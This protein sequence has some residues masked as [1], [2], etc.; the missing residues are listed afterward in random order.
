MSSSLETLS[1]LESEFQL[2]YSRA[3]TLSQDR[4]WQCHPTPYMWY[5]RKRYILASSCIQSQSE[6]RPLRPNNGCNNTASRLVSYRNF[7]QQS[8]IC[9]EYWKVLPLRNG[10]VRGAISI[11][12][13]LKI[14][15]RNAAGHRSTVGVVTKTTT[16]TSDILGRICYTRRAGQTSDGRDCGIR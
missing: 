1:G 14:R 4:N 10:S 15:G 9:Q 5:I 16:E 2:L 3:A 11:T 13:S 8:S 7:D 12:R 6:S